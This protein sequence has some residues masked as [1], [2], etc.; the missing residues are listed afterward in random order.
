MLADFLNTTIAVLLEHWPELLGAAAI[1]VALTVVS[2]LV[3]SIG[4]LVLA[5]M[6]LSGG[7]MLSLVVQIYLAVVRSIP[8]LVLLY[9]VFY[10]LPGFGVLL[11]PFVAAVVVLG[12]SFSGYLSEVYRGGILSVDRGQWEAARVLGLETRATW[13]MVI[14]PQA[15]R[16][17]IPAWGNYLLILLK[18]TALASA[19]TVPELLYRTNIIAAET[20]R[21]FELYTVITIMYF[22][23]NYPLAVFVRRLETNTLIPSLRPVA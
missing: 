22:A 12:G 16:R 23:I 3:A 20:F 21:Y 11:D 6:R 13:R 9:F 4:G 17:I 15:L 5:V 1:T 8:E 10:A 7:R 14:L 19:V 2:M 18:A